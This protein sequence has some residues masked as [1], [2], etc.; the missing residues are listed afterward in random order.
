M[1]NFKKEVKED[2]EKI[3]SFIPINVKGKKVIKKR[4]IYSLWSQF[5]TEEYCAGFLVVNEHYLWQF[6][7]WLDKKGK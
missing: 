5:S 4:K 1:N 7:E 2:I 3:Y 6:L